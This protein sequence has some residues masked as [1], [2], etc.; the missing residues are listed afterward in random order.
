LAG[1]EE[2]WS[3]QAAQTAGISSQTLSEPPL[4]HVS[5][6]FVPYHYR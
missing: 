3:P 4:L 5:P 2:A 1:R 6:A